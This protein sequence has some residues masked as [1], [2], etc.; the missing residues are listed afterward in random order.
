MHAPFNW[1]ARRLARRIR[2]VVQ[3]LNAWLIKHERTNALG[4]TGVKMVVEI[5]FQYCKKQR[6]RLDGNDGRTRILCQREER[7]EPYVGPD[8]NDQRSS[9]L[10]HA[11]A[12]LAVGPPG[13]HLLEEK[14]GLF[15]V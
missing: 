7:E 13:K 2:I 6:C 9:S 11:H 12:A 15:R 4:C 3:R 14:F 5:A 8:V 1:V 10:G